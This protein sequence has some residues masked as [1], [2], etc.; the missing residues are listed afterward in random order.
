[1]SAVIRQTATVTIHAIRS[2]GTPVSSGSGMPGILTPELALRHLLQL[3]TD[4]RT[5]LV[6]AADGRVLARYE[7]VG[8][9]RV[10]ATDAAGEPTDAGRVLTADAAGEPTD[11][12]GR[13]LTADAAVARPARELLGV[14]NA[15]VSDSDGELLAPLHRAGRPQGSALALKAAGAP[16][17]VVAAG[18]LALLP[19]LRHDLSSLLGDM[20]AAPTHGASDAT[21]GVSATAFDV[22]LD[23]SD[24]PPT[25]PGAVATWDASRCVQLLDPANF[26]ARTA[27][28]AGL[29]LLDAGRP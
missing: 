18:P 23:L 24:T 28:L 6:L 1:M 4:V 3:S 8:D 13:V 22:P 2:S 10:L 7:T 26:A 29:A 21:N 25:V 17:L 15:A 16:T 9:G 20:A 19:L 12:D 14:L 5:A 27:I 11:A